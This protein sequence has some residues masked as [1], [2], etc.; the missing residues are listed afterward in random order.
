MLKFRLQ[1]TM[2]FEVK[3]RHI[4]NRLKS[5][6]VGFFSRDFLQDLPARIILI[7]GAVLVLVVW[8]VA[9]FRFSVS[10]YQVPIR[11]NSF[12]GVTE[13]GNWYELYRVPAFITLCLILNLILANAVF[14]K[15]KM[16]S[17]IFLGINIFLA[18][19]ALTVVINLSILIGI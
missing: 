12:L 7:T 10:E 15:D 6:I 1:T 14:A 5:K 9:I 4:S 3:T 11:Y 19:A 16:I 2:K 17:Y 8:L 18:I 13:L